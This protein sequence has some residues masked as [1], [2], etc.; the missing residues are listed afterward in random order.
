MTDA[1]LFGPAP[2]GA[3]ALYDDRFC[4]MWRFDLI[5]AEMTCRDGPEV[6]FQAQLARDKAVAPITRACLYRGN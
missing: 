2:C 5:A 4:R 1:P 3:C 6:V